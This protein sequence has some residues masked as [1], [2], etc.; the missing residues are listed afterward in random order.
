MPPLPAPDG[1]RPSASPSRL[2]ASRCSPPRSDG[3]RRPLLPVSDTRGGEGEGALRPR[4]GARERRG[5]SPSA[6]ALE[7]RRGWM[8]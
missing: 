8:F 2:L 4:R 3:W 5:V 1:P 7:R 6:H